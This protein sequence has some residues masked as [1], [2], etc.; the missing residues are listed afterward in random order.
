VRGRPVRRK[1]QGG[2]SA[3]RSLSADAL[4]S[5]R[6]TN[7]RYTSRMLRSIVVVLLLNPLALPQVHMATSRTDVNSHD[8]IDVQITNSGKNAVS[9]CMEFGQYSFKAG[10]GAAE[11]MEPTPIPFYVQREGGGKWSTLLN[12]PD[13]GSM[14]RVVV[15]KAGESQQ[16][17]FRLGD[18]GRMRLVLDYWRGENDGVCEYPKGKKT[19]RSN[20]FVV[21]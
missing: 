20:I 11:D 21:H 17:P 12:G 2:P 13:I 9:Y 4:A 15:L 1:G 19:T 10:S 18:R 8:R 7:Q 16:F 3:G 6:N 5:S 14:R